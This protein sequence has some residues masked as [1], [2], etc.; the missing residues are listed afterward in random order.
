MAVYTPVYM[1]R[2]MFARSNILGSLIVR[3]S[4]V[5]LRETVV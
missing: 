2:R 4:Y 5:L 1:F 3:N